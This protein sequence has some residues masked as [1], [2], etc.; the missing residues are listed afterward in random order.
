MKL[1]LSEQAN[2]DGDMN[3][4]FSVWNNGASNEDF[5]VRRYQNGTAG[6]NVMT[7]NRSSGKP[8]S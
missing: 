3:Y 2:S 1:E 8:N 7:I 4:G 5:E 6:T